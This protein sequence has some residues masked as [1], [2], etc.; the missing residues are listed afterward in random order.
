MDTFLERHKLTKLTQK[1]I[2][3]L[4]STK[5]IELVIFK[6]LVKKSQGPDGF[7]GKFYQKSKEVISIL[8]KCF[9]KIEEEATLLT[10]SIRLELLCYQN[11]STYQKIRKSLTNISYEYEKSFQQNTSKLN[12][13]IIKKTIHHDQVGFIS[14]INNSLRSENKCNIPY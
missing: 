10:H 6:F 2:Y 7:I 5:K 9:P 14:G 1:E 4:N 11:Y 3:N 12:A 8:Q 13:M